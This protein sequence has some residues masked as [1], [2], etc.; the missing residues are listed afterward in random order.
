MTVRKFYKEF[1]DIVVDMV[2][3]LHNN[4]TAYEDFLRERKPFEF[5]MDYEIQNIYI[6]DDELVLEIGEV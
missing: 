3:I 1:K 5:L 2:L 4:H 6:G